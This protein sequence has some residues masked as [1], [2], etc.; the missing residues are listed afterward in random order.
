M[1]SLNWPR[2]VTYSNK[3]R[4]ASS[5][6]L[7]RQSNYVHS[8]RYACLAGYP[9]AISNLHFNRSILSE[10]PPTPASAQALSNDNAAPIVKSPLKYKI[11][12]A[13]VE[14]DD[15]EGKVNYQMSLDKLVN[16]KRQKTSNLFMSV[17]SNNS[18]MRNLTIA[19]ML[20]CSM[21][22]LLKFIHLTM[23]PKTSGHDSKMSGSNSVRLTESQNRN[24]NNATSSS[25]TEMAM[26]RSSCTNILNDATINHNLYRDDYIDEGLLS[27]KLKCLDVK[28]L[29]CDNDHV[30]SEI[31]CH[32][33]VEEG[34]EP[35][36]KQPKSIIL[37]SAGE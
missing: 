24:L 4:S 23:Q 12:Q 35:Y 31:N 30:Y 3:S 32:D 28:E 29:G 6:L 8:G 11:A 5:A 14:V 16:N 18:W 21:L 2:S 27:E 25:V 17:I 9:S 33:S 37:K 36:Y 26:D 15:K 19:I 13:Y 34:S 7:I 20:L 10:E 22:A 1:G